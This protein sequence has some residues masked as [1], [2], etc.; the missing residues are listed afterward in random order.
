M[1]RERDEELARAEQLLD[2]AAEGDG[3]LLAL[4]GAAG[5]GKTRL[6]REIAARADERAFTVL[7]GRGSELE[8]GFAFGVLRQA[9]EPALAALDARVRDALFDGPA[10]AARAVVSAPAPVAQD[11]YAVVPEQKAFTAEPYGLGMNAKNVDLVRFVN[12]RLAQMREDGEWTQIYDR[13]FSAPLG[14]APSPPRA[15]YGRTA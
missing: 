6:L 1:L 14:P 5:S 7:T 8:R 12:A 15:V 13:W 3:A 9:L 4:E 2:R 11:P 10:A